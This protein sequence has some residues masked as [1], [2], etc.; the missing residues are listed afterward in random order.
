MMFKNVVFGVVACGMLYGL[1]LQAATLRHKPKETIEFSVNQRDETFKVGCMQ[2]KAIDEL[3]N[4]HDFSLIFAGET[5]DDRRTTVWY[6]S[7]KEQT[8]IVMIINGEAC[9]LSTL[10]N[11]TANM[12]AIKE[13]FD[14]WGYDP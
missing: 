8:I 6:N 2:T 9:I 14:R 13:L 7:E 4:E 11:S 1:S 10:K 12:D 5:K 3:L